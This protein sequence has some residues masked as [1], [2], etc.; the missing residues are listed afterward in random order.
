MANRT[1]NVATFDDGYRGRNDLIVLKKNNRGGFTVRNELW[2][3]ANIRKMRHSGRVE[4]QDDILKDFDDHVVEMFQ[5]WLY[6]QKVEEIYHT[7]YYLMEAYRMSDFLDCDEWRKQLRAV[8]DEDLSFYEM[9]QDNE[10]LLPS[11]DSIILAKCPTYIEFS[12]WM[13][14]VNK[15]PSIYLVEQLFERIDPKTIVERSQ[16]ETLLSIYESNLYETINKKILFLITKYFDNIEDDIFTYTIEQLL[17]MV[18][19]EELT[20][21]NEIL[22]THLE[23]NKSAKIHKRLIIKSILNY[24]QTLPETKYDIE[25][26]KQLNMKSI[27]VLDAISIIEKN[28][29]SEISY[30]ILFNYAKKLANRNISNVPSIFTAIIYHRER[31]L[32]SKM[33]THVKNINVPDKQGNTI[34]HILSSRDEYNFIKTL[35]KQR[36][37]VDMSAKNKFN[38]TAMNIARKYD[39]DETIAVLKK[40]HAI[41]G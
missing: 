18:S 39:H 9:I 1:G 37:D 31:P 2:E 8:I 14:I 11:L 17:S 28:E 16:W 24:A 7:S 29:K 19:D 32:F 26:F 30:R 3:R 41:V 35:L 25:T 33:I 4:K 13:Y 34:L 5:S 21:V 38:Q 27:S 6:V 15:Q 36:H 10:I 20:N 40:M 23:S 22:M 12:D